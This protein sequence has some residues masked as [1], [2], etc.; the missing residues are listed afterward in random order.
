[1]RGGEQP[2]WYCCL[3]AFK[4]PQKCPG[5]GRACAVPWLQAQHGCGHDV[6]V[7]WGVSPSSGGLQPTGM[8]LV[9]LGAVGRGQAGPC[10]TGAGPHPALPPVFFAG[11]CGELRSCQTCTAGTASPNGSACV[12]VGCGAPQEPGEGGSALGGRAPGIPQPQVP[13]ASPYPAPPDQHQAAA[14]SYGPVKSSSAPLG[15]WPRLLSSVQVH[16]AWLNTAPSSSFKPVGFWCPQL[17]A[18]MGLGQLWEP[19][20]C[21]GCGCRRAQRVGAQRVVPG[22]R[23]ESPAPFIPQRPG[24]ACREGRQHGGRVCSTTPPPC[25]QVTPNPQ[26]S[27]AFGL[28]RRMKSREATSLGTSSSPFFSV[29]SS[30]AEIP[31]QRAPTAP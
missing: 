8:G 10:R 29:A 24:A 22:S 9:I 14:L 18:M 5:T 13:A 7:G 4:P 1:M 6:V 30:S 31:H 2:G 20:T 17:P 27:P 3:V 21:P 11:E 26:K 15:A 28:G 19:S 16:L 12:W 25:A 23:W